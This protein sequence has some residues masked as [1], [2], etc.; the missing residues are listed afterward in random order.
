MTIA[1]PASRARQIAPKRQAAPV[2]RSASVH[3]RVRRRPRRRAI[4]FRSSRISPRNPASIGVPAA[5]VAAVSSSRVDRFFKPS[6][7]ILPRPADRADTG[8]L[9]EFV[10]LRRDH[11][12]ANHENVAGALLGQCPDQR[13]TAC[14]L[15]AAAAHRGVLLLLK[16]RL[17]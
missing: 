14:L 9:P 7:N 13:L 11:A 10:V 2:R 17:C 1:A 4:F 12:A 6:I 8:P 5:S 16:L 3:G 15:S